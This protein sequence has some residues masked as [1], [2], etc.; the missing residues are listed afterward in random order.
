[1]RSQVLADAVTQIKTDVQSLGAHEQLSGIL[2]V[3]DEHLFGRPLLT[4]DEAVDDTVEKIG[5]DTDT[6]D[7]LLGLVMRFSLEVDVDTLRGEIQQVLEDVSKCQAFNALSVKL[8]TTLDVWFMVFRLYADM[9]VTQA[10]RDA[11]SR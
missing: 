1:M 6:Y 5:D 11:A 9:I 8:E 10:V 3:L 7:Q 2:R 4:F